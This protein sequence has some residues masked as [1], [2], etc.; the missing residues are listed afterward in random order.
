MRKRPELDKL[1]DQIRPGDVIIV[2]KYDRLARSLRD[3]LD[4]VEA[5]KVQGGGFR[6]GRIGQLARPSR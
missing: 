1:L 5:I 6:S 4:I 2:T 3:L